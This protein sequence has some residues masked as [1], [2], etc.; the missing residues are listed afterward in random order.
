MTSRQGL[1]DEL[2]EVLGAEPKFRVPNFGMNVEEL[3][4]VLG[5]LKTYERPSGE[6]PLV[7]ERP[8]L[9]RGA[10]EML[11]GYRAKMAKFIAENAGVNLP[12]YSTVSTR[13]YNAVADFCGL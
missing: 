10:S 3:G 8:P 13:F 11:S 2:S 4:G 12:I 6:R 9:M 1:L 5:Q 7:S